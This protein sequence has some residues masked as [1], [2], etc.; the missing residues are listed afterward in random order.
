MANSD[1]G[2]SIADRAG[3]AASDGAGAVPAGY[4][5]GLITAHK[6]TLQSGWR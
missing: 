2:T 3:Y 1:N 6:M 5:E 4:F